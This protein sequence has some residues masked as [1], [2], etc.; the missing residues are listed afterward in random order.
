MLKDVGRGLGNNS[1][2]ME[3]SVLPCLYLLSPAVERTSEP[4]R[5]F[6]CRI[7]LYVVS[8]RCPQWVP[9]LVVMVRV[10]QK[11]CSRCRTLR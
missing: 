4:L 6:N 11:R 2:R 1:F 7:E 3:A 10:H 8:D 9:L 5:T